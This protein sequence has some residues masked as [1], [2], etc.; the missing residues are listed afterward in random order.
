MLLKVGFQQGKA[1]PCIFTHDSKDLSVVIHGDYFT[2]LGPEPQLKWFASYLQSQFD[3]N[4]RGIMGPDAKDCKEI[5]LLNRIVRWTD[6]GIKYEADL[7]HAEQIVNK[8][9]SPDAKPVSTPSTKEVQ[10]HENTYLG[11][12]N[13]TLY[14]AIC[15]R[16]NFV[17]Q[18]RPDIQFA[19]K[20]ACR[21][22]AKPTFEDLHKLK[23]IARYLK[24][25]PRVVFHWPFQSE[26]TQL[27]AYT[28]TDWAGCR[29]TRKST[30]GGLM[31][32][33]KHCIRSYSSTQ[34]IIALSSGEAEYYGCVKAASVGLAMRAMC[35]DFGQD[36][37]V[38]VNTDA[39]TAKA[40]VTRKGLGKVRHMAERPQHTQD[41]G[42]PKSVRHIN[43][44]R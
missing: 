30:Q 27:H 14:K 38:R 22:M 16:C 12:D 1:S 24:Q 35:N 31:F 4:M 26:R 44:A 11:P 21:G 18:D 34:A 9:V 17:A 23:L 20:E 8:L 28:D 2:T 32:Y 42:Q 36:I 39:S 25:A 29:D 40:I 43:Q 3:I 15:A 6:T 33:G 19:V 5:R 37:N 10:Q 7:R 41:P 13:A